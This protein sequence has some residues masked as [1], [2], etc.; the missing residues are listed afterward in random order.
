[1][2]VLSAMHGDRTSDRHVDKSRTACYLQP[3]AFQTSLL[4]TAN[5]Y[6]RGKIKKNRPGMAIKQKFRYHYCA[7][8]TVVLGIRTLAC[9]TNGSFI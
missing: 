2:S 6:K 4:I 9:S 5:C 1:M 7:T 3:T 8:P